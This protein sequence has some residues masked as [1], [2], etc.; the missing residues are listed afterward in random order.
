MNKSDNNGGARKQ[1]RT[2]TANELPA[3]KLLTTGQ[4]ILRGSRGYEALAHSLGLAE[5]PAMCGSR[6]GGRVFPGYGKDKADLPTIEE[7]VELCKRYILR[8]KRLQEQQAAQA[9]ARG[10]SK[11]KVE[12]TGQA[13]S[14]PHRG[15]HGEDQPALEADETLD[16]GPKSNIPLLAAEAGNGIK[17]HGPTMPLVS[18]AIGFIMH[19]GRF[20]SRVARRFDP[21]K[22]E[23]NWA[24]NHMDQ[25]WDPVWKSLGEDHVLELE[26]IYMGAMPQVSAFLVTQYPDASEEEILDAAAAVLDEQ[27]QEILQTLGIWGECAAQ[28][29][30]GLYPELKYVVQTVKAAFNLMRTGDINGKGDP[31]VVE[32]IK[33]IAFNQGD[34]FLARYTDGGRSTIPGAKGPFVNGRG[35][36]VINVDHDEQDMLAVSLVCPYLHEVGHDFRESVEQLP[37]QQTEGVVG[38]IMRDHE[39]GKYNLSTKTYKIGKQEVPAIALLAQIFG[40]TLSETDA[41]IPR[42]TLL[43]G[44]A[45]RFGYHGV[46]GALN[47]KGRGI[48]ATNRFLRSYGFFLVNEAGELVIEP[49]MIDYVRGIMIAIALRNRGFGAEAADSEAMSKQAAGVPMPKVMTWVNMDP[50]SKFK[51]KIQIPVLD[52]V[53]VAE[54]VV[55]SIINDKLPCLGGLSAAEL[56]DFTKHHQEKVDMLVKVLMSGKTDVPTDQGDIYPTFVA[57]A[58]VTALWGMVAEGVHPV[59]AV[60]KVEPLARKMLDTIAERA[61]DKPLV[62]DPEPTPVQ[63]EVGVPPTIPSGN[64]GDGSSSSKTDTTPPAGS[65]P[66]A[67]DTDAI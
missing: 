25:D 41:D 35:A 52:L 30:D 61:G 58:A 39:A 19:A 65:V 15:G 59:L 26:K 51:F 33:S 18:G 6:V 13:Q 2:R 42:G 32:A 34:R 3:L 22:G 9:A 31:S 29:R 48:F 21:L 40:Q 45:Y 63:G 17:G 10:R 53:Q 5:H 57:A 38:R 37:E 1:R 55:D 36:H 20:K 67:R 23:V 54:S 8:A 66:P 62:V 7:I 43:S 56:C 12:G 28:L 16:T 27:V 4:D 46:F 11:S 60:Y 64:A 50:K 44:P 49:H 47:S 24:L 14:K